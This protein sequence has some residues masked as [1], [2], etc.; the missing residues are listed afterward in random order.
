MSKPQPVPES[1]IP[2][3]RPVLAEQPPRFLLLER[4]VEIEYRPQMLAALQRKVNTVAE[5]AQGAVPACPHCGRNMRCQDT[6]LVTWLARCGCLHASVSRY[7]CP[8]C[9]YEC[10]PLLDLLGVEPG[11]ICGALAR[12]L[13][14]LATVAPYPL[15]A[16]LAWLLLGVTISPMGIWRVAQRLGES[17]ARHTEALSRYHADSRSVGAATA[18]APETVILGVD[19]CS[20]GMQVRS[21]RRRRKPGE[22]PPPLP[23]IEEGRFREVKTGVLLLP[24]E[25]VEVSPGRRSVVRRFLVTCLGDADTV[26]ARLYAQL[27]E[28]GWVGAHT[29]VVIV[30]DGAEWIWN[31]AAMFVKRCEILDFWHAVEHAWGFAQLRYGEGSAQADRWV[32]ALAEDL[33]A[34]K[35]NQVLKRLKRL[36]PK[37]P[38]LR[39]SLQTLIRYYAD[40]AGRM[41][42][43]E[44]LRLGYGI[45]SGAVESAHKQVVHAR[46]RQAGMRW[47]EAGAR[48]LLALRLLLLNDN[49]TLLDRLRMVSLA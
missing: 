8:P 27:R 33:R 35:V 29:V 37:T 23:V 25:R 15:A 45:G 47:S 3:A 6:R 39:E 43:D 31:R 4:E 40:N 17:A 44:Y 12:L 21:T 22:I 32:H 1:E 11:R 13:A 30:G 5:Q 36:R 42:Y 49:W 16:R 34:G 18:G 46:F 26:F 20:L 7:R 38:E 48:R 14:L 24:S 10:R 19:G 41:R 28:L 9:R 2:P